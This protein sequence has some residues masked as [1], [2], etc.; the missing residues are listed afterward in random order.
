MQ[1][2]CSDWKD[3]IDK[4]NSG[5]LFMAMRGYGQYDGKVFK[6]CPWC[7]K[8]LVEDSYVEKNTDRTG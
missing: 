5:T 6:Y 7:G 2:I 1:C 8:E 4:L 3:N